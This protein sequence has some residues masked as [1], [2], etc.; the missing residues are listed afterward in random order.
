MRRQITFLLI[1]L[2]LAVGL[3]YFYLIYVPLVKPFQTVFL[4]V[5]LLVFVLTTVKVRTGTLFFIFSFPLINSLPYF[6]NIFENIPHAPTS[7]VLFLFYLLGWL[8]HHVFYPSK[9]FLRL[10]V[11][12]PMILFSLMIL[13]SAIITLLRYANFFPF[14]SD[15][16]YELATNVHGVT[17]GGAIMSVIF[18]SLNYLTGFA[19]F[20]V[21]LNT[22]ETREDIKRI[23]VVLLISTS[24]ALMVGSYQHLQDQSFGNTPMRINESLI[25][26]TFKNPL[27]FG[28]YCPYSFPSF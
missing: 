20:F 6:F 14:L 24:I 10:S 25:N 27:S 2:I 13:I 21:L 9:P 26:A 23:L 28:A 8:V 3:Y 4:P 19:F 18:L 11:F 16:V 5:L 12:R 15:H 17:A 22:I 7:L 1:A